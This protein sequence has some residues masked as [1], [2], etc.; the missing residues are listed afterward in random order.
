LG[1]QEARWD[2]GGTKPA[3]KYTFVYGKGNENHGLGS[4]FIIHMEIV[5]TIIR[6]KFLSIVIIYKSDKANGKN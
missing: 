6:R 3:G 2:R 4:S 1:V 5:S